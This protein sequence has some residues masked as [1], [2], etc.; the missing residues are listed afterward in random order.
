MGSERAAILGVL[1][2][3]AAVIQIFGITAYHCPNNYTVMPGDTCSSIIATTANLTEA[4]FLASNPT[5]NCSNL[6]AGSSVCVRVQAPCGEVKIA[7]AGD[8]CAS[9]MASSALGTN[10]FLVLNPF[11][12]CSSLQTGQAICVS[13]PAHAAVLPPSRVPRDFCPIYTYIVA[14]GDTCW[15]ISLA[16]GMSNVSILQALNPK[17]NCLGLVIGQSLCFVEPLDCN[18]TYVAEPGDSCAKIMQSFNMQAATLQALNPRLYCPNLQV[19]QVLCVQPVDKP[20]CSQYHTIQSGDFCSAILSDV[21]LLKSLNPGLDCLNLALGMQVCI[22]SA[23]ST[24]PPGTPPLTAVQPSSSG[25]SAVIGIAVGVSVGGA[26]LSMV[27]GILVWRQCRRREDAVASGRG[28]VPGKNLSSYSP[29]PCGVGIDLDDAFNSSAK[30]TEASQIK[31]SQAQSQARASQVMD[32]IDALDY[33]SWEDITGCLPGRQLEYLCQGG[34]GLLYKGVWAEETV[35]VKKM[36]RLGIDVATAQQELTREAYIMTSCRHPNIAQVFGLTREVG[37]G[38]PALVMRYYE[39]GSLL[40][41]LDDGPELS[42]ALK[43]RMALDAAWGMEYLHSRHHEQIVHGDLKTSNLLLDK[44]MRVYISDFGLASM[45]TITST[46]APLSNAQSVVYSA[47]E[48]L[49]GILHSSGCKRSTE[50][51]VYAFSIVLY[52]L[53]TGNRGF[54][55]ANEGQVVGLVCSGHRPVIPRLNSIDS[56]YAN[57]VIC[58][59]NPIADLIEICWSHDPSMRPR[60]NQIVAA[61]DAAAQVLHL[62]IQY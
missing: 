24:I 21:Q 18:N 1:W 54:A 35:V 15:S 56:A 10:D 9:I 51:D 32:K 60:F 23:Q 34:Q 26:A 11:V 4:I 62:D 33:I 12:N 61:L 30:I 25:S 37:T 49:Q 53:F 44:D 13:Q 14:A 3:F 46:L 48:L 22:A 31:L 50:A 6:T 5:V 2:V 59:P 58:V 40:D 16:A 47:P 41:F 7:E 29:E 28:E 52:E 39:R 38:K 8:T 45:K 42:L 57:S 27:L 36:E 19:G 55:G 20:A 43:V 17:L